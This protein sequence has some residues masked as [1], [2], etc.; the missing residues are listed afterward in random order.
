MRGQKTD[1]KT[2]AKVRASYAL[3]N[4]YNKTAK[5][6]GISDKTVKKII[7]ENPKEFTKVYEKKKQDFADK[8]TTIIDKGMELLKRRFDT[9]LENQNE[10]EE[11]IDMVIS[12]S[13]S[14]ENDKL[15]H[16]E[17]MDIVKKIRRIEL[18]NLSE[19]T[20]SIG[21]LYDKRALYKGESTENNKF[22]V[23]IK[24]VK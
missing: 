22:E 3:T 4:S 12:D 7:E 23:N 21:T 15:S 10:L 1:N 17:K 8:A 20:T 19:I 9:A 5:E 13:N 14:D 24:V 6:L 2:K 11:L 18:N 16:K